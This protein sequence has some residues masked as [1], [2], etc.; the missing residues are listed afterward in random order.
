MRKRTIII[1]L[2]L[3]FAMFIMTGGY[4]YW[5]KTLT[6]TGTI[7]IRPS[8]EEMEETLNKL[9]LIKQ[10]M[11]GSIE[12]S[13]TEP[14]EEPE[15]GDTEE[16]KESEDNTIVEEPDMEDAIE[17]DQL[18]DNVAESLSYGDQ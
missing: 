10:E 1:G 18:E 4:G 7:D 14:T 17:L 16:V 11:E 5:Y 8:Q 6:I 2:S 3:I 13:E 12:E 15:K 9:M